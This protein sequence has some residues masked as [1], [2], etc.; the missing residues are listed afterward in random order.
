M[1]VM[2]K[3]SEKFSKKSHTYK[4]YVVKSYAKKYVLKI[5]LKEVMSKNYVSWKLCR[6]VFPEKLFGENYMQNLYT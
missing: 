1:E 3:E 4:L 2:L 5:W 6:K